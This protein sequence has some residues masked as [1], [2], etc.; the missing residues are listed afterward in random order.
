M[1]GYWQITLA[2]DC[3]HLTA[4]ITPWGRYKFLRAPMGLSS[5]GD[6]YCRRG[7]IALAGIGNLQKVIDDILAHDT[8]FS[9]HIERI[10]NI[11]TRCKEQGITLNANKFTFAQE[12]V[13]YV[14]YVISRFGIAAEPGQLKAIREFPA[15]T[16]ISELRT[17]MGMVNQLGHFSSSISST[18]SPL[19]SLLSTKS[20]FQWLPGHE[21]AFDA[22]KIALVS[23]PVL[24]HFDPSHPTALQTDASRRKGLGFVLLQKHDSEWRLVQC[25]SRFLTDTESRYAMVEL[26]LLAA[27]WAVHKCRVFLLGLPTFSLI[28]DHQPLISI[29]NH[30]TLDMVENPRLQRLKS[31]LS[32]YVFD[33][34]WCKGSE[35]AIPDALSRAPVQDPSPEDEALDAE[36]QFC[37]RVVTTMNA[38]Q[39][40]VAAAPSPSDSTSAADPILAQ[41]GEAAAADSDYCAL[42]EAVIDGFPNRWSTTSHALQ[43]YWPLKSELSTDGHLVLYGSRIVV[44][45]AARPD[46]LQRLHASHQGIVRTKQRAR[47]V[48]YWPG[49]T[50]DIER[51]VRS[52]SKCQQHL[53]SQPKE[54]LQ[55]GPMPSRVFEEVSA[56][57]F[58]HAGNHYLVYADRLSNWPC[59][60]V[61]YRRDPTS[62]DVIQILRGNFV[63]FGVPTEFRSDGGPQFASKEFA[64]FMTR[65]GVQHVLSSPISHSRTATLSPPFAL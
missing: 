6:E 58:S 37:V 2:E 22:T 60:A 59:I 39:L 3:Q 5:T 4:F 31:K 38:D 19:R 26:E 36:V 12:Q 50:V 14:G 43:H 10:W 13:H 42:R 20:V 34:V 57:L 24:A 28:V 32:M 65:W 25:G 51:T 23:P 45:A 53:P 17:F 40:A 63:A 54:P 55:R 61:W 44:P 49:M 35:H 18:A 52:C 21:T 48:L 8:T 30:Q 64:D 46:A 16:N 29:L 11:L 47:Q 1:H 15:P 7:D 9:A 62:R 41:L 56:D 33:T 27:V